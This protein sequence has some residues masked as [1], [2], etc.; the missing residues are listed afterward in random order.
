MAHRT[1]ARDGEPP[2]ETLGVKHVSTGHLPRPRT[3]LQN[4][5]TYAAVVIVG[6]DLIFSRTLHFL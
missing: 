4:V 1:G 5:A 3:P 2:D 6:S